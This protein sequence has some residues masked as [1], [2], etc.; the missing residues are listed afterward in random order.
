VYKQNLVVVIK[1]NGKILRED[2][3]IVRLPFNNTY[4]ILIKNLNSVKAL[5]S[6]SID[7]KDILNGNQ[8][9]VN[10]NSDV[11]LERFV[12]DLNRGNKFLF[13]QK[14]KE[15]AEHRG[16]FI[17]DGCIRVEY[18]FE[19]QPE[20]QH[21]INHIYHDQYHYNNYWYYP[22]IYPWTN[23]PTVTYSSG[24]TYCSDNVNSGCNDL[25]DLVL[26][27]CNVQNVQ[28]VQQ[29]T[30]KQINTNFV[31]AQGCNFSTSDVTLDSIDSFAPKSEEG[32]TVKGSVSDQKFQ[33]GSIGKL[34]D[35]KHVIILRLVGYKTNNEVITK[36]ITV[37][38]RLIC[39][40]CGTSNV[41][42]N[43]YCRKCG[44]FLT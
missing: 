38:E 37:N 40:S 3:D 9:I 2:G 15:I 41:S 29:D 35:Q 20:I 42:I 43:Q 27:F 22:N 21:H 24:G 28:S 30:Q 18:S 26:R 36:P 11:E 34:E 12:D 1:V 44:T 4:S 5:V 8:L 25:N 10:P 6:V 13:I 32:V 17:D 16:D 31:S 14:S 33:I 39:S 7:G 23:Y 19:A